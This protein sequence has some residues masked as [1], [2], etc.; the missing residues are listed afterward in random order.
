MKKVVFWAVAALMMGSF[1][2]TSCSKDDEKT[3]PGG[4]G[5]RARYTIM[6][7]GNAGS[8]MDYIIEEMWDE[9]KPMLNDTTDVRMVFLYKYGSPDHVDPDNPARYGNPGDILWF[10]LNN[11]IDLDSL[12]VTDAVQA[13]D[14]P[15]YSPVAVSLFINS[16]KQVCPADNYIFI[17]WGHGG[18]Y[19]VLNDAPDNIVTK[20]VLYDELAQGKGMSMYEFADG[21]ATADPTHFQLLMFHNC[22]MGNIETLTEVQQYADYMFCSAHVL[23]SDGKPIVELVRAIQSDR[24]NTDFEKTAAEMC[25]TLKP[26]YD[27][28]TRLGIIHQ[29]LDWKIIRTSGLNWLNLSIGKLA[30]R[31]VELYP[32]HKEQI[33]SAALMYVYR[34]R[35]NGVPYLIDLDFYVQRLKHFV[36]DSTM[37]ELCNTVH[38]QLENLFVQRWHYNYPFENVPALDDYSLS[39]VFGHHDFLHCVVKGTPIANAYY[40][41]AFNRRTGWARWL[42]VN[43]LWPDVSLSDQGGASMPWNTYHNYLI[44]H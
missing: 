17:L 2:L 18:G 3:S 24:N 33:D 12:R 36:D 16:V 37:V 10:E 15:L 25:R 7:Y 6:V 22:L 41:S 20:G 44:A 23:D 5:D 40:P 43:T 38:T 1:A 42:D 19:D 34:Y 28:M 21:L 4:N 35:V 30:D 29:N 11:T 31:L 8:S 14:F 39:I 32:T 26:Y 9:L 13:P 27:E